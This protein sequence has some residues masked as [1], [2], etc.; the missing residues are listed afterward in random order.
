M[1]DF[2]FFL[3]SIMICNTTNVPSNIRGG[4]MTL[5]VEK[6]LHTYRIWMF[7]LTSLSLKNTFNWCCFRTQS[8]CWANTLPTLFV[9]G[10]QKVLRKAIW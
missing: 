6:L 2:L 8:K 4:Q 1:S 7:T 3:I 9:L 5:A 10:K